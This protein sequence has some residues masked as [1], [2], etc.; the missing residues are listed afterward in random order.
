[1][2][3]KIPKQE[4]LFKTRK[5]PPVNDKKKDGFAVGVSAEHYWVITAMAKGQDSNRV[6][7][8]EQIIDSYIHNVLS[9]VKA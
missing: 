4:T 8:L 7:I 1:M 2:V 9:K 3:T 6:Q 5:M